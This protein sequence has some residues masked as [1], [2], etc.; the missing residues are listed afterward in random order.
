MPTHRGRNSRLVGTL[1]QRQ[2]QWEWDVM[3]RPVPTVERLRGCS[4]AP[5][6]TALQICRVRGNPYHSI[7]LPA[8]P[9][10]SLGAPVEVAPHVGMKQGQDRDH[11]EAPYPH[12]KNQ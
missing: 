11:L 4:Y 3:R 12:G 5:A 10:S 1:P 7:D 8:A 2:V 9:T 6:G